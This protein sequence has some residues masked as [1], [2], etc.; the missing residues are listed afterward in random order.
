MQ[1]ALAWLRRLEGVLLG[2]LMLAMS[3][4]YSASVLVRE[5]AASYASPYAI[6]WSASAP[7]TGTRWPPIRRCTSE[8]MIVAL[9]CLLAAVMLALGF[10]M[11]LV[12]GLPSVL[13]KLALYPDMPA[14]VIAQRMLGGVEVV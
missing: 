6:C 5:F 2:V 7:R 1:G 8:A 9:L 11:F 13:T 3:F 10:E 14:V 4:A 12:M